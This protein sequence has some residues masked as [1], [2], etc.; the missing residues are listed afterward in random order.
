LVKAENLKRHGAA[1]HYV[2]ALLPKALPGKVS[3]MK[4][5]IA[6]SISPLMAILTAVGLFLAMWGIP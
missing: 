4:Q 6:V 3:S 2:Y 1:G 5:L